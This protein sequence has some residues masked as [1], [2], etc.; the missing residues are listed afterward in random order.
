MKRI[1]IFVLLFAGCGQNKNDNAFDTSQQDVR[2]IEKEIA[3]YHA[4][5]KEAYSQKDVNTDSLMDAYFDKDV[6]YVTYWGNSEPI[7]TTKKRIKAAL[8][9]ISDYDNHY[10]NLTVKV[11]GD[12]AYAFFILR[13]SYKVDGQLLDEYLPTTFVLERRGDRW[14]VVHAQR[15]SDYQTMQELVEMTKARQKKG[16]GGTSR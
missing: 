14:I 3:D 16:A 15:T 5:L 9:H 11:Y 4:A 2:K 7:D 12:G 6:Y 8:P 13:Q 1:L 10:E